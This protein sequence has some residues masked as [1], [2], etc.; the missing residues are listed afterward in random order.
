MCVYVMIKLFFALSESAFVRGGEKKPSY[1]QKFV[2]T[3]IERIIDHMF[4]LILSLFYLY[5]FFFKRKI[6][7][8]AS[9]LR[10]N[11]FTTFA[12]HGATPTEIIKSG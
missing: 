5:V 2:P 8:V 3:L 1:V 11:F 4:W 9:P 12:S 6:S 10:I 7:C